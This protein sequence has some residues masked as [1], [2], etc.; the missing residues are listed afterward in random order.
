ME[1][2]RTEL[3]TYSDQ[4]LVERARRGDKD[5][6][7]ALTERHW[8]RCVDLA[9]ALLTS[10]AEAE[11]E[12]QNAFS[13]AYVHLEQYQGDAEFVTWLSR[14]VTN[15]CLMAMRCRRRVRFVYLDESP[16]DRDLAPREVPGAGSDPEGE[17]G[18]EELKGILRTEIQ[19]IPP[20]LR[21]LILLRDIQE[22]PMKEVA[23][24]L[25]ISVP[26]AKS[27][28]LRARIELRLRIMRRL[29]E[30]MPFSPLS[31]SAAPYQRVAFHQHLRP[32]A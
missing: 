30:V 7:G 28:L 11:D 24:H 9:T 10:R 15:E 29:G 19:R 26:A 27:R 8:R 18:L 32:A 25:G 1:K 3:Q 13:K 4:L 17:L 16:T 21:K 31:R 23:D 6:F 20:L 2:N 14:I 12:V 5:A 22:L